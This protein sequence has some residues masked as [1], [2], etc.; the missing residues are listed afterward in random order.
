M[1]VKSVEEETILWEP[2]QE[3][4]ERANITR[5]MKWLKDRKGLDFDS[6]G[7]L[8]E[9]SVTDIEDF[10]ASLWEFF[11]IKASKPYT[12]VLSERKMP[13]NRW[14]LDSELNFA[15]HVF[16]N[17][18][19]SQPA[20]IFQRESQPLVETSWD[21]LHEKV[22]SVAAVLRDMGV[23]RGDRIVAYMPNIPETAI[24]FLASA[25]IGAV[26]S[27]CSP[28][29]GTRSVVDRFKQ[30]EPKILF[31]VDGY[32]YGGKGF[33][34][35]PVIS[36]LQ[37]SLETLEKTVLI[38][39]LDRDV[40]PTGLKDVLMWGDIPRE[41]GGTLVFEQVP[42]NHPLWVVYS[43]GTTGLPKALV[44]S[45]GAILLE[46]LKFLGL[47]ADLKPEDR[48][49][50]F[51]TSGWIM[52]NI[53]MGGFLHGSTV[54][55]F[56]GNPGY[57]N[58]D[59]LWKFAE[60]SGVTIFGT[61]APF[62]I[63]CM[64][65]GMEPGKTYDLSNMRSI[66]STGAPLP[67]EAYQ[68]V[69]EHVKKE[70]LL[71][72]TSGGTDVCTGFVGAC[73][74]LPVKA[75]ELQC[76]CL[77]VKAEAF[78]ESGNPLVAQVG[79]LVITEPMPSMPLYLW[80]DREDQRYIE[81]YFDVYPGVWRHGDWIKFNTDGSSV[82]TG[83]SDST[84]KRMGVRMG[85]SEIYSAVE[86]LPEVLDSLIVGYETTGGEYHMPLFV[87]LKEGMELDEALKT[88]IN[89]K[90]R[91]TLSPRHVPDDIFSVPEVPRT[92]NNKKLEVPVKKILM[93]IRL[94]NA[95]SVDSMTNPQS[96]NYFVDMSK[97]FSAR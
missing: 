77:G 42:F 89:K 41:E 34:R 32:M 9:W 73:P 81:S 12:K 63:A 43:S 11:E 54:L 10:W 29:F 20:L 62:L 17:M 44:Q 15:E 30:I 3:F 68:W 8:W 1:D 49:F 24:A 45:Q 5:Y 35:S 88:K 47:H 96:I 78:D 31:A 51:S 33:D 59:V 18:S 87:V 57:P 38:P 53:V 76:R 80:N 26:W 6:Y 16:R 60:E 56:D 65:A 48:F 19:S 13:G 67:A 94:D 25:S 84:L 83:R 40:S 85:S 58:M 46:E 93:G 90:I 74:L 70:L 64:R 21:E 28:D 39:Y 50:W 71:G 37:Q 91:N 92:L 22:S 2:S 82:I 52:W 75:G 55:L 69:Y 23:Q 66:G 14:F 97:R 4:R 95:V 61:S 79:E 7:P 72:S 36:E 86:D 27:S